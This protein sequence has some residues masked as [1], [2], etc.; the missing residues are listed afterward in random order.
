MHR[1]HNKL[2]YQIHGNDIT[3]MLWKNGCNAM[4]EKSRKSRKS[5]KVVYGPHTDICK[6]NESCT[7]LFLE[8]PFINVALKLRLSFSSSSRAKFNAQCTCHPH[9][10][11]MGFG[12]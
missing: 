5:T 4:W 1:N 7:R 6:I 9:P 12:Q 11:N 8:I 3:T 2:P 10:Y